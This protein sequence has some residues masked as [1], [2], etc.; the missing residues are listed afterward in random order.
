MPLH[1]IFGV[2]PPVGGAATEALAGVAEIATVA[3]TNIGTDDARF[4]TPLKARFTKGADIASA[5]PLVIGTD[6]NYF[7]VTGTTNFA[8]ITVAVG[9]FF[10]LQFDGALTMTHNGTTLDLPG[11]ADIT[12][13][14]GDV[15]IGFATAA[16]QVHVISYTRAVG[17]FSSTL[18]TITS[19]GSL[20]IAHGLGREPRLTETWLECAVTEHNYSVGDRFLTPEGSQGRNAIVVTDATNLNVRYGSTATNAFAINDKTTG[21]GANA[22][23]TSWRAIFRAWVYP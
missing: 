22:T 4:V 18:Q 11:E 3:E 14:A 10:V 9:R 12:T 6:G 21:A 20:T 17:I 8:S 23:N 15:L 1:P 16:N 13:A 7:D 2:V 19:A 5:D